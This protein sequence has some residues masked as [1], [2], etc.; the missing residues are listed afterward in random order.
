MWDQNS[1]DGKDDKPMNMAVMER[2]TYSKQVNALRILILLLPQ[3]HKSLLQ[4]LFTLLHRVTTQ[5][6]RNRMSPLAL[7][8]VFGPVLVPSVFY[9]SLTMAD[10]FHDKNSEILKRG[11]QDAITLATR[12]IVLNNELF[13]FP[14]RLINDIRDNASSRTRTKHS[15]VR[16]KRSESAWCS[17][18]RRSYT[19]R[20]SSSPINTSIRY[21]HIGYS[22]PQTSHNVSNTTA[23]NA[24]PVST[25]RMN[26][27][28]KSVS[29]MVSF[30]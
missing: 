11:C 10:G 5:V 30:D 4:R 20:R 23:I 15:E 26:T 2:Y 25:G 3:M 14:T 22:T 27:S 29:F 16:E 13:L 17:P 28:N 9:E 7:G 1:M 24:S 18:Y 12:M 21:A 8:T 19:S 6:E